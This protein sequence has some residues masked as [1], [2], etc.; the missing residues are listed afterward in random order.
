[1]ELHT[2]G[3]RTQRGSGLLKHLGRG[4]HA[5]ETPAQLHRR[6][7]P[8]LHASAGAEDQD[9]PVNGDPFRQK[10]ARHAMKIVEAGTSRAVLSAYAET[11]SGLENEDIGVSVI[12]LSPS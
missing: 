2:V 5:I 7:G 3:Q 10:Q 11:D 6:N 9:T 12:C 1:V 4:V 8:Q